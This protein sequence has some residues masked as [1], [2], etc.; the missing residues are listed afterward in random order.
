MQVGYFWKM[1]RGKAPEPWAATVPEWANWT[2][3]P[4]YDNYAHIEPG[5]R[6]HYADGGVWRLSQALTYIWDRDLKE[7]LDERIMSK[8]GIPADRW[9]WLIG[10]DMQQDADFYPLI[11]NAWEYL[12]PPYEVKG[13]PVRSGPG[14]VV[15]SA[16]DLARFGLLVA[17]EGN[18]KGEQLLDPQWVRGHG[19]GNGS[20]QSGESTH[21]TSMGMVTTKG[22]DYRYTVATESFIPG[23]I[24]TGP[25]K[26]TRTG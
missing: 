17:T 11:P 20:G 23:E 4:F 21:Y 9:D 26:V 7:V 13:H 8:I 24:F 19:G 25:V 3:D 18:W 1:G 12:D 15:I 14:W 22:I 2:G 5:T 6:E 10:R 16:K